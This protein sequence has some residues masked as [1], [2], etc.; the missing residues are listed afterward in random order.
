MQGQIS[1]SI[2]NH[3][4]EQIIIYISTK[5]CDQVKGPVQGQ[6]SYSIKAH[7]PQQISKVCVMYYTCS[8]VG[9]VYVLP[10]SSKFSWHKNFVKHSKLA[11]LLIFVVKIS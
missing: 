8:W 7:V 6:I 4:P 11:K 3:V 9:D 10:Y 5:V 2:T 1:Y